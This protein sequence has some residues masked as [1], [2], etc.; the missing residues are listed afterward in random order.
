MHQLQLAP[1]MPHRK[2]ARVVSEVL[3][4]YH[5]HGN[6]AGYDA[7]VRMVQNFS[8]L[9]PLVDGHGNFGSIDNDPA[10][11]MRYTEC[12]LTHLATQTLLQELADNTVY[13]IANFDGNKT[14]YQFQKVQIRIRIVEG[15][16]LALQ[17]ID[18]VIFLIRTMPNTASCREALMID[19]TYSNNS[20]IKLGAAVGI[21]QRTCGCSIAIAAR[22]IDTIES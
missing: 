11:A 12:R 5:P 17:Q 9:Y 2:C 16:F 13:F 10:A 6:M 1:T 21:V 20:D 14:R 4:K 22:T 15:F 19:Q 18:Q 3:G 7:L 8:T